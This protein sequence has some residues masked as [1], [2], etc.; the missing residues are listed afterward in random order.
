MAFGAHQAKL[1]AEARFAGLTENCYTTNQPQESTFLTMLRN[2][3]C[4]GYWKAGDI[5][6]CVPEATPKRK[7]SNG[8]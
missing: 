2:E 8:K 1:S 5:A 3:C 4:V 7:V 6:G